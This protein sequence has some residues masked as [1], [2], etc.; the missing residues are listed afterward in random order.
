MFLQRLDWEKV[1][2]N[3]HPVELELGAGDGGFILAWAAR[4]P[5]VNFVAVERLLGRVRKI[6]KRAAARG[7]GNLRVLR[8]ESSYVVER[9]CPPASV[10]RIHIMFPDPWP[11]RK[12]HKHR[13]IQP[14]FLAACQQALVPGG[15]VR[16][17]TD[18]A[19]YFAAARTI[20]AGEP[21]WE[22]LGAWN[23]CDD[24][25]TDFQQMWEAEGRTTLR[26]EW[27]KAGVG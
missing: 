7:L 19:E 4:H 2:G 5:G 8:L 21:G 10:D 20:W 16:L 27:R 22:E 13:L 24:P 17:T 18:H 11:K 26:C 6:A 15:T 23:A 14:R 1:F 9:M 12:H 25:P 3:D